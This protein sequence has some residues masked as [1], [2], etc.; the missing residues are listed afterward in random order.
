MPRRIDVE[1]RKNGEIRVEYSGFEGESCFEEA[2]FFQKALKE[3]GLWAVPVTII[4]KSSSQ[5][6][7]E[8][9]EERERKEKVPHG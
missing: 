2:E 8:I 3:L 4:R 5:I 7:D 9:G 6:A 1:V